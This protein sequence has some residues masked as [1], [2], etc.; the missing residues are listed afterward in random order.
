MSRR[1]ERRNEYARSAT[2]TGE[3]L[4]VVFLSQRNRSHEL[5]TGPLKERTKL[6]TTMCQEGDRQE[7][8]GVVPSARICADSQQERKRKKKREKERIR[9]RK[10]RGKRRGRRENKRERVCVPSFTNTPH[11]R[12]T[13]THNTHHHNTPPH[14]TP[15]PQHTTTTHHQNTPH[16]PPHHTPYH[17][18]D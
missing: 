18:P 10:E 9:E 6:D 17:T 11:T 2:M 12:T 5:H 16:T 14:N 3:T 7:G 4:T 1:E 15:P 8:S 13:T